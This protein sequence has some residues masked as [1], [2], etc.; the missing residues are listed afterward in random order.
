MGEPLRPV[1]VFQAVGAGEHDEVDV[2]GAVE[3][4]RLDHQRASECRAEV[5]RSGNG[6]G[7]FGAQIGGDD[8]GGT[9]GVVAETDRQREG[10]GLARP[11]FPQRRGR[12]RGVADGVDDGA[13][14]GRRPSTWG[15]AEGDAAVTVGHRQRP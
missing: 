14:L 1:P 2:G 10:V 9:V 5:F 12:S 6:D 7:P 8:G 13:P 15:P 11:A 3:G 4:G